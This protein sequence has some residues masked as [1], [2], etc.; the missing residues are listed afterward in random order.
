MRTLWILPLAVALLGCPTPV[1]VVQ[2]DE[3][4]DDDKSSR[5]PQVSGT[6]GLRFGQP[7][8]VRPQ[9]EE[10]CAPLDDTAEIFGVVE[11]MDFGKGV[12]GV[13]VDDG[14]VKWVVSYDADGMLGEFE[15][16]QILGRG[17]VC[18]KQG[19]AIRAYHFDLRSLRVV[20][21]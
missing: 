13:I 15:K 3:E 11:T 7:I 1:S 2:P 8:A 18:E 16:E 10:G 21:R 12:R 9:F 20:E 14:D 17:V 4:V 6:D 5:S 19:Q